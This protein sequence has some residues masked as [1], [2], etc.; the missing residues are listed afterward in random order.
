MNALIDLTDMSKYK[1][2]KQWHGHDRYQC[3][4]CPWDTIDKPA[5]LQKHMIIH[6]KNNPTPT[7]DA[8]QE[9]K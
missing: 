3:P 2:K 5:E 1:E 9:D 7:T 4:R 8:A 6:L